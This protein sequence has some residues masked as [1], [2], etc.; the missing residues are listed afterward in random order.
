MNLNSLI[1]HLKNVGVLKTP[2]I[3]EAFKTI[4]R[5]DFV[6]SDLKDFAYV[7]E[8][9]PIGKDQTISQPYTV[10]FMLELLQPK[11]NDNI[12][13]IGYGSGWQTA[14][15]AYI[16]S[17]NSRKPKTKNQILKI[18][19]KN[20]KGIKDGKIYA[21]ELVKELCDFGRQNIAKYNFTP[22][23]SRLAKSENKIV[24]NNAEQRSSLTGFIKKGIVETF[25][26]SAENGLAEIAEKIGGF[27]K[28]VAAAAIYNEPVFLPEKNAVDKIPAAW[29]NQLKAG[30]KILMPIKNSIWLFTKH[31]EKKFEA[32]EYPGFVFVPFM[33][34]QNL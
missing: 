3:I 12:L 24:G 4:D 16:V 7:D 29:K 25:C 18:Q 33:K 31:S 28:I 8:A 5:A 6:P 11:L 26:Q 14:L 30:G 10:A 20:K 9:L 2:L 21:V 15:L 1:E 17:R 27:D 32:Q 13:D 19:I 34:T 22:L 23:E